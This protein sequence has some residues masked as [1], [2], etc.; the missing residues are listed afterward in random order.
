MTVDL[1]AITIQV[2]TA[3]TFHIKGV[4]G[5]EGRSTF[6]PGETIV[7]NLRSEIPGTLVGSVNQPRGAQVIEEIAEESPARTDMPSNDTPGI[8]SW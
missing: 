8:R 1:P 3:S 5:L 4:E 2:T 6:M 7:I